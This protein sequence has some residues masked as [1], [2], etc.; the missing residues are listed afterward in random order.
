MEQTTAQ[1]YT[2]LF[3]ELSTSEQN[4]SELQEDSTA[5]YDESSSSENEEDEGDSL[6]QESLSLDPMEEEEILVEAC[7]PNIHSQ[8]SFHD[9]Y[10]HFLQTF[11]EGSKVFLSSMLQTEIKNFEAVVIEQKEWELPYLSSLLKE[12]S[13]KD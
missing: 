1:E 3:T 10:A 4:I 13:R 6:S 5:I 12:L 2:D 7:L 11:E 8:V 9:P